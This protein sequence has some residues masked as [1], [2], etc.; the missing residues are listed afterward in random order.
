[1]EEKDEVEDDEVDKVEVVDEDGWL[2]ICTLLICDFA[3][4]TFLF[5]KNVAISFCVGVIIS[6]ILTMPFTTLK[7]MIKY[8]FA[9][10]INNLKV[11]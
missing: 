4:L 3:E 8:P 7:V 9:R 2:L 11:F 1:M 6:S 10:E 5:Y